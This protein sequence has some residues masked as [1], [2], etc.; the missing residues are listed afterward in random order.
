MEKRAF[1]AVLLSLM[2]LFLYQSFFWET[3]DET[4]KKEVLPKKEVL[5]KSR[6]EV[7]PERG[8]GTF[9]SLPKE[10]KEIGDEKEIVVETD[11]YTAI[12]ASKGAV[13]KSWQLK[14]YR[15]ELGKD[16][17]G[18]DLISPSQSEGFPSVQWVSNSSGNDRELI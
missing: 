10:L 8:E 7:D 15:K 5:K 13:L 1:L 4:R 17:Q 6:A 14:R 18:I 9:P 16:S 2:V 11:L 12:F 3:P